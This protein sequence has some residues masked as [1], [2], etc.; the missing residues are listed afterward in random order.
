MSERASG[1]CLSPGEHREGKPG[2]KTE[3]ENTRDLAP[4]KDPPSQEHWKHTHPRGWEGEGGPSVTEG[5]RPD[6]TAISAII[7]S[8]TCG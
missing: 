4:E 1:R 7:F 5:Q 6:S 3:E 8:P 2:D